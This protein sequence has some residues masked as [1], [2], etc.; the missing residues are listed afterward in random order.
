MKGKEIE[1]RNKEIAL[2]LGGKYIRNEDLS[3][4]P[5]GCWHI[6][7]FMDA[8]QDYD[9]KFHSDWNWLMEAVDFIKSLKETEGNCKGSCYMVTTFSIYNNGVLIIYENGDLHGSIRIDHT[10]NGK[11]FKDVGYVDTAK[12]AIFIAV[13]DF[14]KYINQ[15]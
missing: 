8:K 12:E 14:A 7:L 13:S 10:D 2:M 9:L 15:L 3:F 1:E 4:E 11:Y 6:P 5:K